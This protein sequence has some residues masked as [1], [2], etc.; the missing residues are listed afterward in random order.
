MQAL[1]Y[2][3]V[4]TLRKILGTEE[5][6]VVLFLA[7]LRNEYRLVEGTSSIVTGRTLPLT[8]ANVADM[9]FPAEELAKRVPDAVLVLAEEPKIC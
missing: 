6:Q 3:D 1:E 9:I 8:A 4:S 2:L 7:S 5:Y